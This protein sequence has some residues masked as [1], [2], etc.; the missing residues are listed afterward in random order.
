MSR[1]GAEG[2]KKRVSEKGVNCA[3]ELR[4]YRGPGKPFQPW[5]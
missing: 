1:A 2:E 4:P 5:D 3:G